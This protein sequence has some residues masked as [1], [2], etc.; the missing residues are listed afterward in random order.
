MIALFVSIIFAPPPLEN[1][2]LNVLPLILITL[3]SIH[4]SLQD[5]PRPV[6]PEMFPTWPTKSEIAKNKS[7]REKSPTPPEGGAAFVLKGGA[8]QISPGPGFSLKF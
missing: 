2:L 1:Y 8:D 6:P 4:S 3:S 7:K 5:M